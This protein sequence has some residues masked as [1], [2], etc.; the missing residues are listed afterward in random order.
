MMEWPCWVSP[1][2][3]SQPASE[4]AVKHPSCFIKYLLHS[5][6]GSNAAS[7]VSRQRVY[8]EEEKDMVKKQVSTQPLYKSRFFVN[9][10]V[11]SV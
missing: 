10:T 11:E 9:V 2:P 8:A 7:F 4:G 5:A 6:L 3:G 1:L